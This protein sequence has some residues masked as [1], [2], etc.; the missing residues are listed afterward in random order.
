MKHPVLKTLYFAIFATGLLYG[1]LS[2]NIFIAITCAIFF[3][4]P[5]LPQKWF[6]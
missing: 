2:G 4:L 6:Y 3:I 1:I 5:L